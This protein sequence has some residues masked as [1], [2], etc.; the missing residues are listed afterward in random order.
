MQ[1]KNADSSVAQQV[2]LAIGRLDSLS[3][4]PCVAIRYFPKLA[5]GQFSPAALADIIE[6][7]PVLATKILSLSGPPRQISLPSEKFSLRYVLDRLPADEVR[8]TLLS[9][10]VLPIA[11]TGFSEAQRISLRKEL[12]LHSLAAACCARDIAEITLPQVDPDIAYCAALLHDIGKLALEESMPKSFARI[13][14]QARSA[15]QCSC[16]IERQHLGADHTT[17]GKHLAQKWHL[18]NQIVL[19]IWLHHSDTAT[20]SWHFPEARIAQVVRSADSIARQSGIGQSGSFD[21]PEPMDKTAQILGISITQLQQIIKKLPETVKEKS[22][23]LGLDSPDAPAQYCDIVHTAAARFARKQMDLSVENIRL[24]TASSHLDFTTEFLL[25][26]NSSAT[27]IDIAE[28]FATRWQR[29]YQTGMVC[30]YLAAPGTPRA[31]QSLEAVVVQGLGQSKT[32]CLDV[33]EDVTAI[34]ETIAKSFAILDANDYADWL[35]EQLDVDFDRRQTKLVPLLSAGRAVGAIVFELHWPADIKL[36]EENFKIVTS[37]AGA[38]LGS[39]LLRQAQEHLAERFA[40]IIGPPRRT[41]PE[42][43]KSAAPQAET[44]SYTSGPGHSA[45]LDILAEMVSGIAHE[46]NNPLSVISG[47]AQLLAEAETSKKKKQSLRQIYEN[48]HEASTIIE[49]LMSFTQ[50]PQ[51]KPTQTNVK[52]I[53]DEAIQLASQK[54]NMENIDVRLRLSED[55]ENVFADSAQIASAIANII[56]NSLESY[57]DET[58]PITITSDTEVDELVIL[59]ISDEGCGMDEETLRKAIHPFFSAKPAGRKRGMGLAY[60]ARLI[61]LNNGTLDISSQPGSGTMVS[62]TLPHE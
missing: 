45:N 46:L 22:H 19:A 34:P 40:Q 18:P 47:R 5:E 23:L 16:T 29:F 51:P 30:L 20:I 33:P 4:L 8:N 41:L 60:A 27:A 52:Q 59:Q 13:F 21:S 12:L 54:A 32:I 49:D 15:K 61:Q 39:A 48:T 53:L 38:I 2:E 35:F 1:Q 10:K 42:P 17:F 37:I 6:S 62:I 26:V 14:E 56:S 44:K 25:S 50:P 57:T 11:E 9:I 3:T 31:G 58:G 7:E 36:F 55:V 43:S 24:Q 28:S